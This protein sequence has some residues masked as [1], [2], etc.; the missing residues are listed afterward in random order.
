MTTISKRK[1]TDTGINDT[2]ANVLGA[3]CHREAKHL[4]RKCVDDEEC[5]AIALRIICHREAKFC[6]CICGYCIN[7]QQQHKCYIKDK[8]GIV[9][10]SP[11]D[12]SCQTCTDWTERERKTKIF[13][14]QWITDEDEYTRCA[15][16]RV[17]SFPDLPKDCACEWY[18]D[19]E[20]KDRCKRCHYDKY[21]TDDEFCAK[22]ECCWVRDDNKRMLCSTC[23][24]E[25]MRVDDSCE[26]QH[27]YL[28]GGDNDG[29]LLCR[30]CHT[31]SYGD[32]P[33]RECDNDTR[34]N[35]S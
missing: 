35:Y 25:I 18:T 17:K 20:G 32:Q 22:C 3:V 26:C 5:T 23:D 14:D 24:K 33:C 13:T 2:T 10:T 30:N 6:E 9:I 16:C 21:R 7:S 34:Y 31:E 1:C 29:T 11:C 19:E 28:D 4:K 15:V 27:W 12:E 8:A